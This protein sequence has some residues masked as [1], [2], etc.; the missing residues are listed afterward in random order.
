VLTGVVD[1][2][3]LLAAPVGQRPGHVGPDLRALLLP[4]PPV[5]R[6][7]AAFRCDAWSVRLGRGVAE[8]RRDGG[9]AA[10]QHDPA[11][12]DV[13]VLR[14]LCEAAWSESDAAWLTAGQPR[15]VAG[16]GEAEDV[17]TRLGA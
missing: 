15:V 13:A 11:V 1:V 2:G 14:A 3:H 10:G 5:R 17:L 6:D 12:D 4:Q 16:D 9:S 8:V 7:G